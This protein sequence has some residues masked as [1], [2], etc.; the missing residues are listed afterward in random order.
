MTMSMRLLALL[1]C[2]PLLGGC[3]LS[4]GGGD[5]RTELR[6]T[7]GEELR[8]LKQALDA[9]AISQEEYEELR[10]TLLDGAPKKG[11]RK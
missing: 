10:Q 6:H 2:V 11:E 3:V 1:L 7:T 4:F 9:G 8:D 5:S